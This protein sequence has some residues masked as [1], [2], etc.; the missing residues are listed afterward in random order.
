MHLK[1][2]LQSYVCKCKLDIFTSSSNFLSFSM[3]RFLFGAFHWFTIWWISF[4]FIFQMVFF[5]F[6][7]FVILRAPVVN[8]WRFVCVCHSAKFV[9][10]VRSGVTT[11]DTHTLHGILCSKRYFNV[12]TV[13]V[14][15]YFTMHSILLSFSL[16]SLLRLHLEFF[17]VFFCLVVVIFCL[18]GI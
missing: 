17:L 18:G 3:A 11:R 12:C 6:F 7:S 15:L 2:T 1:V 5:S 14:C 4:I 8:S 10:F 13:D 16:S 9:S